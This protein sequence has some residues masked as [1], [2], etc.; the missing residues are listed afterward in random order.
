[1]KISVVVPTIREESIKRFVIEWKEVFGKYKVNLL[2]I[3]DNP[4]KSF[5]LDIKNINFK[6]FHYSWKDIEKDLGKDSWIIPRRTSAIKSYGFWKAYQLNS[7]LIIALDDDCYP[8]E[9]YIKNFQKGDLIKIYI[10]N[11]FN[12]KYLEYSWVSTIQEI[13]PRGL[14]YKNLE[15]VITSENVILNHGLWANIP[16]LDAKTQISMKKFLQ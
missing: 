4:E 3:E 7:D 11:L 12:K 6:I 10:E 1:M 2:I 13:R 15:R 9:K 14:P 8:L 5:D 16:D